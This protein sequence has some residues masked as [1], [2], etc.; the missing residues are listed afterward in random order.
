MKLLY[1]LHHTIN[2]D[3][4]VNLAFWTKKMWNPEGIHTLARGNPWTWATDDGNLWKQ[5]YLELEKE[6]KS[7][8]YIA[9]TD[10]KLWVSLV[11]PPFHIST[12][13]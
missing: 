7:M 6:S 13:D 3:S 4:S 12:Q 1:P 2:P 8:L 10:V 9:Q 11:Q 5:I